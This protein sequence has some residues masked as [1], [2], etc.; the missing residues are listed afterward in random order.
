MVLE[1]QL[2]SHRGQIILELKSSEAVSEDDPS[3]LDYR[4]RSSKVSMS[5][6]KIRICPR[7]YKIFDPAVTKEGVDAVSV[8]LESSRRGSAASHPGRAVLAR[9]AFC[10]LISAW[11]SSFVFVFSPL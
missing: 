5:L 2:L 4:W 3:N 6:K 7:F 1:P 9:F 11:T 8:S 10:V